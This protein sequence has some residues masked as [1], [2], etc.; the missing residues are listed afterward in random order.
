MCGLHILKN[1]QWEWMFSYF[2][3]D[4]LFCDLIYRASN[5][6]VCVFIVMLDFSTIWL[7]FVYWS[8][9]ICIVYSSCI[10]MCRRCVVCI[11][12]KLAYPESG[13]FHLCVFAYVGWVNL[14]DCFI[15]WFTLEQSIMCVSLDSNGRL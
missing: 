3:L 15:L 14:L 9:A 8:H 10:N 5:H 2:L 11:S 12:W 1:D 7:Q 4:S 6:F 13:C